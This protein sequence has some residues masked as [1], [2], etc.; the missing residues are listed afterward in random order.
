MLFV[1]LRFL[2]IFSLVY[3]IATADYHDAG[4]IL[5]YFVTFECYVSKV[6][7]VGRLRSMTGLKP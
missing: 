5:C 2:L 4:M 6:K 3:N 7:E 1:A